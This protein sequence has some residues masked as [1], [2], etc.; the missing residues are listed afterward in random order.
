MALTPEIRSTQARAFLADSGAAPQVNITQARSFAAINF[1]TVEMRITQAR[2][3]AAETASNEIWASQ[4]R[5]LVAVRGRPDNPRIRDWTFSLDGHDFYVLRLGDDETLVYDVSAQ[6]WYDWA[7]RDNP[8]WRANVGTTWLG[9]AAQAQTFG[10]SVI[11]GDDNYGLLW[12]LDPTLPYDQN[13]DDLASEQQIYFE[14]VVMGQMVVSGR[15][16]IPVYTAFLTADLGDPA[17]VGASVTLYTSDDTGKTFDDHGTVTVTPGE[18]SPELTWYSLGQAEAPG[19]L[20][21]IIDNGAVTRIDGL[22]LDV[23]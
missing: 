3:M 22:Q 2:V 15:S 21:K 14:R 11:V 16:A 4:A 10:S 7:D 13:P 23:G 1:P 5:L 8:F 18:Y 19:R 17:F 6:A 9:A 12:F 20:F